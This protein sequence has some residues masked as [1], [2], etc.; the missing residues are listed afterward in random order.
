MVRS[1]VQGIVLAAVSFALAAPAIAGFNVPFNGGACNAVVNPWDS[2]DAPN[3]FAGNVRCVELCKA[4][5]KDCEK[6]TKDAA[7]C[8]GNLITD[9][10]DYAKKEC[11]NV[12]APVDRKACRAS[13]SSQADGLKGPLKT[14]RDTNINNC[15]VWGDDC[16]AACAGPL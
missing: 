14:D 15:R 16:V 3:T 8:Q 7:S 13:A 10:E 1:L 5:A 9:N 6:F 4:T 2:L 12:A 11:D